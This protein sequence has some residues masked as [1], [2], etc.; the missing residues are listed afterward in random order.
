MKPME[1]N[2]KDMKWTTLE[3]DLIFDRPWLRARRDK[4]QLPDGTI[5]PE[6][7]VL[8]YPSWINVIAITPEGKFVLVRQYRHGLG[9]TF[10]EL[11]AGC[12]EQGED[13]EAGARRELL[14]ETGYSGGEW[15]LISVISANP[16][17][18]NNLTYCYLAQ[19]VV[20]T[21]E[22]H[23][24]STEDIEVHLLTRDELFE[25]LSTDQIK[26]ALMCAP[27]WKYFFYNR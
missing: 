5:H 15:Q 24:D 3:S 6:Y 16:S 4:V 10:F 12:V 18:N 17:A 13:P 27:L 2:L 9:D 23:L 14:E 22:Q 8:E 7:Y 19:G 20:H 1:K 25:L 11:V 21:S 26:Q